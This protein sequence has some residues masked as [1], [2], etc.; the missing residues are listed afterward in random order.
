MIDL[1]PDNRPS[2]N[3]IATQLKDHFNL[4]PMQ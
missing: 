1:N 3:D 2:A 4:N